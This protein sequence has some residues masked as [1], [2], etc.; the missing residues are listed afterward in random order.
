MYWSF[1]TVKLGDK[2]WKISFIPKIP[3]LINLAVIL[4]KLIGVKD[5]YFDFALI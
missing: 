1:N 3:A 5:S 4:Y 2:Y